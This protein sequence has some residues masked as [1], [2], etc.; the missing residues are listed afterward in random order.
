MRTAEDLI[1]GYRQLIARAHSMSPHI[2]IYGA[3]LTPFEGAFEGYY[4]PEKDKIRMEVNEWIRTGGAFDAVID[5]DAAI[6]DPDHP[7]RI[8]PEYDSGDKLHPGDAG[9]RKMADSIELSL[10]E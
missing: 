2:K 10:F 9:Y 3:T 1:A 5:F 6:K 7:L 4:S 8:A